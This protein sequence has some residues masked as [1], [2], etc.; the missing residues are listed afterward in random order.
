MKKNFKSNCCKKEPIY[1]LDTRIWVEQTG[2]C[3]KCK[4]K[5]KFKRVVNH[6]GSF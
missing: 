3:S 5:A 1:S 6:I 2:I 4:K